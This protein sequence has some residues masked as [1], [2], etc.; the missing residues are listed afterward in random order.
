MV[1]CGRKS[2]LTWKSKS[3]LICIPSEIALFIAF[4][5]DQLLSQTVRPKWHGKDEISHKNAISFS[6]LLH[7]I[8]LA[9]LYSVS[10]MLF[11]SLPIRTKI[12]F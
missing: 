6:Y 9:S 3:T 5:C 11:F 2:N 8:L 7:S 10:R 1:H 4:F 12:G